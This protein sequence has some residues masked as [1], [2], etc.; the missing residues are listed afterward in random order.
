MRNC[1][2][3][4]TIWTLIGA[5]LSISGADRSLELQL[6]IHPCLDNTDTRSGC[7]PQTRHHMSVY[8][9]STSKGGW[10]EGTDGDMVL[11]SSPGIDRSGHLSSIRILWFVAGI[12]EQQITLGFPSIKERMLVYSPAQCLLGVILA[13]CLMW[14]LSQRIKTN[15]MIHLIFTFLFIILSAVA[16]ILPPLLMYTDC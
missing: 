9:P 12:T 8:F 13:W 11:L 1:K 2:R 16:Q 14:K 15:W 4:D 3:W 10:W 5:N 6:H 7:M